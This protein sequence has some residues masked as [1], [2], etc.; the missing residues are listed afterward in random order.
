MNKTYFFK[1][2]NYI[3]VVSHYVILAG[4]HPASQQA[5][6]SSPTIMNE[7]PMKPLLLSLFEVSMN[8]FLGGFCF[9]VSRMLLMMGCDSLCLLLRL[10]MSCT[11]TQRAVMMLDFNIF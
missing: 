11:D 9:S 6:I 7:S 4:F 2:S 5:S 3:T 1:I 10:V 8:R